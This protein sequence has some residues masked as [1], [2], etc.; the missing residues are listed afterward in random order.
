VKKRIRPIGREIRVAD[1]CPRFSAGRARQFFV[2]CGTNDLSRSVRTVKNDWRFLCLS[3]RASTA[4]SIAAPAASTPGREQNEVCS[5]WNSN[6]E[7]ESAS[8]FSFLI[9]LKVDLRKTV[10]SHDSDAV[11]NRCLSLALFHPR[12]TSVL[13]VPPPVPVSTGYD[14]SMGLHAPPPYTFCRISCKF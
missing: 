4:G 6:S 11:S 3:A 12:S 9:R 5:Q 7:R 1:T 13:T 10:E 14:S 2:S 8:V